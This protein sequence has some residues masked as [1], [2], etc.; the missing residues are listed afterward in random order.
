MG[1]LES[2]VDKHEEIKSEETIFEVPAL[3][4]TLGDLELSPEHVKPFYHEIMQGLLLG[5]W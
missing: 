1:N 4:Q 2:I 3:R 5:N